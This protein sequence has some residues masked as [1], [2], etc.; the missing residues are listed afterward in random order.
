[1]ETA[2]TFLMQHDLI[3]ALMVGGA[4]LDILIAWCVFRVYAVIL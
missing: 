3:D 4:G 1:M 2:A